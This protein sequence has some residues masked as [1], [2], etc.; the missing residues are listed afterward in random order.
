[1]AGRILLQQGQLVQL[2]LLAQAAAQLVPL[3]QV[4]QVPL[5]QQAQ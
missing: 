3:A 5:V 1:M 4:L 2:V